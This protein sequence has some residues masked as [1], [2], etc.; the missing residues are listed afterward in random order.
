[1]L[2]NGLVTEDLPLMVEV[3]QIALAIGDKIVRNPDDGSEVAWTVTARAADE[4]G[5][6]VVEYR[7][8]DGVEDE[9]TFTGPA[10]WVSVE[11]GQVLR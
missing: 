10:L 2:M 8:G 1:M 4:D 9:F 7:D 11:V 3:P 5:H 6:L